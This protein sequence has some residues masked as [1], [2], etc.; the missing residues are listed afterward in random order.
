VERD[1]ARLKLLRDARVV[2]MTTSGLARSQALVKALEPR[3][4][5]VEEA[6][7]VFEAQVTCRGSGGQTVLGTA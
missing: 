1:N 2:G 5:L 3:V 7:E 6:A 4:V